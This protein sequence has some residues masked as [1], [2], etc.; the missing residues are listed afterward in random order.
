MENPEIIEKKIK[1]KFQAEPV[2]SFLTINQC[3]NDI[4]FPELITNLQQKQY[5]YQIKMNRI[6]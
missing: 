3:T 5:G 2:Q 6:L 4:T 1:K